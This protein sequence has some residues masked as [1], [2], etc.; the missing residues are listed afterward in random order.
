MKDKHLF[1]L[2]AVLGVI[3]GAYLWTQL[4]YYEEEVDA[5]WSLAAY[6]NPY[7]AAEQFLEKQGLVVESSYQMDVANELTTD[8]TLFISNANDVLDQRRAD[9]LVEW[10]QA[11]GHIIIAAQVLNIGEDDVF[12]SQFG[13]DKI[14]YDVDLFPDD[15][16]FDADQEEQEDEDK[17]IGDRLREANELMQ[18]E[19]AAQ[20]LRREERER[21]EKEGRLETVADEI[22]FEESQLDEANIML[23]KFDGVD[24]DFQIVF[25]GDFYL[26]HPSYYYEDDVEYE[27]YKPFYSAGTDDGTSFM[28]FYVDEGLLTVL[29]DG[30]IWDNDNIGLYDHA[31]LLETLTENTGKVVFLRGAVVPSLL[32]LIWD[33][34]REL[35]IILSLI[36]LLWLVYRSRRFGPIIDTANLGRRSFRE[37]LSAV[38]DF[39][40]RH[41]HRDALLDNARQAVWREFNKKHFMASNDSEIEKIQKM[42]VL[43]DLPVNNIQALMAGEA[44]QDEFKFYQHVKSLQRL[45]N[46]L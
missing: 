27:D 17:S 24:G 3:F 40:W 8:A 33:N 21:L 16:A 38:G 37:H 1:A 30:S 28:Q 45:R 34:F 32:E 43:S 2:V 19:Q 39:F 22:A 31:Y 9:S 11:G 5:G 6:L 12:L 15:F 25:D 46:Q 13:V 29:G 10:M 20:R 14:D 36:L 42:S 44:P 26:D 18:E 41:Q 7:L 23:L 35:S 4:E